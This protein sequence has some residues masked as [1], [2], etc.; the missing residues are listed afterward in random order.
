MQVALLDRP[1]DATQIISNVWN[2]MEY[3]RQNGILIIYVKVDFRPGGPEI[4][5]ANKIFGPSKTHTAHPGMAKLM[6]INSIIKSKD[7]DLVVL[8]KE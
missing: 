8:K 4:S 7:D 1:T 5:L 2:A 6:K 3:A